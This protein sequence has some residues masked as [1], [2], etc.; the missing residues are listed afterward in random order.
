MDIVPVIV[1]VVGAISAIVG[2]VITVTANRRLRK[3][4]TAA[5]LMNGAGTLSDTALEQINYFRDMNEKLRTLEQE[6]RAENSIL[7]K[8]IED[9]E[10]KYKEA[11]RRIAE[12]EDELACTSRG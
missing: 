6:L 4:E 12:L 8:Q 9:L 2:T 7:R 5:K 10:T 11:I 3:A 1:S